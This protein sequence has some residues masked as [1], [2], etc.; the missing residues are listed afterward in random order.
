M[1]NFSRSMIRVGQFCL[2]MLVLV[3]ILISSGCQSKN[4]GEKNVSNTEDYQDSQPESDIKK[5]MDAHAES[6][7]AMA[8]VT[9]VAIGKTDDG[10]DCIMILI[11]EDTKEIRDKLPR[12][13]QGHPVCLFVS[14]EIKPMDSN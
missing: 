10:I 5:V 6:L 1:W 4:E 3:V 11:L 14:G 7:M 8:G 13:I 2:L 12:E 9:G